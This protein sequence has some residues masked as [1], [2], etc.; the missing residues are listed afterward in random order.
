MTYGV[1]VV[2]LNHEKRL[3][4]SILREILSVHDDMQLCLVNNGSHDQTLEKLNQFK[5]ENRERAN[6]LDMKKTKNHKT[7]FKAGIRF[8][9]NTFNLIR[10]G[11]I[12]F[13]DI[14]NF[15]L[16]VHNLQN[17]FIRDK[18]LIIERDSETNKYNHGRELLRNTFNLNLF[19]K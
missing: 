18:D 10:I 13:E 19:I 8:F 6:V 16:F 2:F 12:A 3:K 14:E 5:F 1:V 15:S 9:T 17:D 7:A 4:T 11:Y